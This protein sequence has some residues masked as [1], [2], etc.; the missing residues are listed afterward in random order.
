M[1]ANPH[2]R[3]ASTARVTRASECPSS[4]NSMSGRWTPSSKPRAILSRGAL[5]ALDAVLDEG[6]E[7]RLAQ[8]DVLELHRVREPVEELL[9]AAQDDGRDDDRELVD[10]AGLERL[11]DD[12]GSAHH[13]DVLVASR[14]ASA[15]HR[16]P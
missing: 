2:S 8:A 10:E 5:P 15:I 9:A 16:L 13:V 14:L 7:G 11:A 12:V 3:A 1:A 4:P 6:R